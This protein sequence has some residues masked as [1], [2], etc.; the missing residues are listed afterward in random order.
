MTID[1]KQYF[2]YT[3]NGGDNVSTEAQIKASVK[4]NKSRDYFGLRPNK[5]T[6]AKIREA[7]ER[8]GQSVQAYI[9]QAVQS[10]IEQDSPMKWETWAGSLAKCPSCGYEYC[11]VLEAFD[12]CGNC[13][14]RLILG[15][16]YNAS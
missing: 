5:E 9:L 2:R 1:I 16:H 11:D 8:A 15:K 10:R 12:Y 13:G 3:D 7:A 4:Y 14:R 6:G